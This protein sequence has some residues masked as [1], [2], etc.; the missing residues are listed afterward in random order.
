MSQIDVYDAVQAFENVLRQGFQHL[1]SYEISFSITEKPDEKQEKKRIKEGRKGAKKLDFKGQ[2]KD[3]E[4]IY[5][6]FCELRSFFYYLYKS[7]R[8]APRMIRSTQELPEFFLRMPVWYVEERDESKDR[9][10][11]KIRHDNPALLHFCQMVGSDAFAWAL[12]MFNVEHR[13]FED[14][15]GDI[16]PGSLIELARKGRKGFDR[17]VL[18]T[19]DH[20]LAPGVFGDREWP[21][22]SG[23]FLVGFLNALPTTM[24]V[25][26]SWAN[27]GRLLDSRA[28]VES[29]MLYIGGH[30]HLLGK[31]ESRRW[32]HG[33]RE[34]FKKDDE[35]AI[36]FLSDGKALTRFSDQMI[37][38]HQQGQ[39]VEFLK[40]VY[41]PEATHFFSRGK[42]FAKEMFGGH[43][44]RGPR[45]V[46][47]TVMD[48]S[49]PSAA[50]GSASGMS[51]SGGRPAPRR[52]G[53]WGRA[54][55]ALETVF[56][57]QGIRPG[58]LE[59][60]GDA[61][62]KRL[63]HKGDGTPKG[64][65][66]KGDGPPK[67]LEYKGDAPPKELPPPDGP[68]GYLPPPKGHK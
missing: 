39:V 56:Q 68:R 30:K 21:R 63:E 31:V 16:I 35:P 18:M 40:G 61:P 15:H 20:G 52:S 13:E 36:R 57:D 34:K 53:F 48:A 60:K 37:K 50:A 64:L 7:D 17:M 51:G 12:Q 43:A 59:Y 67:G 41:H 6:R 28:M 47:G 65:E 55:R 58:E 49:S 26:G 23:T 42:V 33:D 19:S 32:F 10:S 2:S 38:A 54:I 66:Y 27:T 4:K 14:H 46:S 8:L 1:A 45:S 11:K 9:I 44:E 24:I 25:L 3:L 29:T 5:D 22:G 62:L